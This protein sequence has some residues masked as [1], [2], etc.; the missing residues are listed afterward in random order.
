MYTS[1]YASV[2]PNS[3][4]TTGVQTWTFLGDANGNGKADRARTRPPD[5]PVRG[6][7]ELDRSKPQGSQE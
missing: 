1:E 6:P 5:Q 2:N 7:L 3:I 4:Q